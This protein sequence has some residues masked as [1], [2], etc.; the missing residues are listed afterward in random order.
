VARLIP[1]CDGIFFRIFLVYFNV[2]SQCAM[3]KKQS[4]KNVGIYQART[5]LLSFVV[6]LHTR[7][8]G[9]HKI[10]LVALLMLM[11]EQSTSIFKISLKHASLKNVQLSGNSG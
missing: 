4:N 2:T 11:Y 3:Y 9:Q 10:R 8:F 6:I 5:E 7:L 1:F